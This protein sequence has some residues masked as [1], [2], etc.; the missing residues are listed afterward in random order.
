MCARHFGID[1]TRWAEIASRD[2]WFFRAAAYI[3]YD[4]QFRNER[5]AEYLRA[6]R[7]DPSGATP[8]PMPACRAGPCRRRSRHLTGFPQRASRELWRETRALRSLRAARMRLVPA[9][10][11]PRVADRFGAQD[12]TAPDR[13]AITPERVERRVLVVSILQSGEGRLVDATSTATPQ[14]G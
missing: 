10:R 14:P 5:A 1:A 3:R 13:R 4:P 6:G 8:R 11:W 2:V 12:Q 9:L 7:G